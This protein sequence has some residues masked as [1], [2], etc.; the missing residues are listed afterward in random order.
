V[1][2]L[3]VE[4]V[5]THARNFIEAV[6][7]GYGF[8]E[9]MSID[10]L[11]NNATTFGGEPAWNVEYIENVGGYQKQYGSK[12]FVIKGDKLFDVEFSADPLKV[13]EMRPIGEKI[14]Q[15]FQFT[16]PQPHC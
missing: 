11:K 4:P 5:E 8:I 12:F 14:L 9:G 6:G 7:S 3:P 2:S 13:P 1:K 10:V 16:T 15:S